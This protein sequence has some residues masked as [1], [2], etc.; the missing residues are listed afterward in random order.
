V[1]S[2][3]WL[4]LS[5]AAMVLVASS[6]FPGLA[7]GRRSAAAQGLA[8]LLLIAGALLGTLAAIAVLTGAAI[9]TRT[10]PGPLPELSLHLQLDPLAAFF[11]LPVYLLG[12]AGTLY[13]T[14]YW[15]QA[16][17]PENGRGLRLW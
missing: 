7:L 13:G 6:G 11:L 4:D 14:R 15:K 9:E 10:L 8:S 3:I 5:V 1:T 16:E 2:T 12:V 17:H